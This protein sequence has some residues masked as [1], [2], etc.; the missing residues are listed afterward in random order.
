MRR[1]TDGMGCLK[2]SENSNNR[3]GG[4]HMWQ[5]SSI[6]LN[7]NAKTGHAK[8]YIAE[9]CE[10]Y[11]TTGGSIK[12]AFCLSAIMA[13]VRVAQGSAHSGAVMLWC[14]LAR[15]TR[16]QCAALIITTLSVAT[17]CYRG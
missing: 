10:I 8:L 4:I 9:L 7:S 11:S 15:H 13:S 1:Y 5:P 6:C 17:S 3:I 14:C 2:Q 16:Q 12:A